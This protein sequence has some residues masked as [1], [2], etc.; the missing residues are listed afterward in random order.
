MARRTRG[1]S[2]GTIYRRSDGRWEARIDLGWIAG[3]RKRKCLYGH[4]RAEVAA[5]LNKEQHNRS[6]GGPVIIGRRTVGQ[7][8]KEWLDSIKPPVVRPRTYQSYELL[9]RL[10]VEPAIGHIQLNKLEPQTIQAMLNQ[11]SREGLAPQT[12][13]HIR[14]VLRR[15]LHVA[16]RYRYIPYN[17]AT[18][19]ELPKPER[20][21]IKPLTEDQ[22]R[23]LLDAAKGSR[24]EALLVVALRLGLRRGEL[25]GLQ[26]SDVDLD[27]RT[28]NVVRAIQRIP[29]QPLTAAPLKTRG[30]RRNIALPDEVVRTLRAH[31][32]RQAEQRLAAGAEWSDQGLTFPNTV[33]KPQEPRKIDAIFKRLLKT[34]KLPG[35]IR[36]HDLRHTCATLLLEK[37][38][39]LYEVS[40]LLGHSTIGIT[41]NVYGHITEGMKRELADKMDSILIAKA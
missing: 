15:A 27:G 16:N 38:A 19:V 35:S 33:G 17:P 36:F 31:R 5:M 32:V 8:M 25:L 26:W 11:K 7:F 20:P 24:I 10:H 6:N 4:S 30:S 40:R 28:L 3:K 34:A 2:E 37:D 29:G 22:A 12:V 21:E 41:A 14:T 18:L 1:K 9:N 13:R 39:D 23:Q